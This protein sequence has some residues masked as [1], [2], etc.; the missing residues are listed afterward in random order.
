[1][2]LSREYSFM[3]QMD[4]LNELYTAPLKW[5]SFTKLTYI[6]GISMGNSTCQTVCLAENFWLIFNILVYT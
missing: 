4:I 5:L 3:I 1:M 6:Y 2:W